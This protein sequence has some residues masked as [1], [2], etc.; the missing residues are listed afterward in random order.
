MAGAF[1]L[2]MR[3]ENSSGGSEGAERWQSPGSAMI[4]LAGPAARIP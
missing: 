1:F 2:Y 3:R 4:W